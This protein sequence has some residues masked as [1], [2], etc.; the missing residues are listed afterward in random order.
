MPFTQRMIHQT[1]TASRTSQP[2]TM[3]VSRNPTKLPSSP[4][5]KV[6]I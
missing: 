6:R 4:I 3:T 1:T 2:M 5:Q